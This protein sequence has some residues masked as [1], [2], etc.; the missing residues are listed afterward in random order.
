MI[1]LT[2]EAP[3]SLAEALREARELVRVLEDPE[4]LAN[5]VIGTAWATIGLCQRPKTNTA[6]TDIRF[7]DDGALHITVRRYYEEDTPTT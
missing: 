7:D 3:A 6:V 5:L 2:A 1:T 4:T